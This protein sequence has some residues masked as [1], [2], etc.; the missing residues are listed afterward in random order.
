MT[1]STYSTNRR[2]VL[3]GGAGIAAA[4]IAAGTATADEHENWVEAIE[5]Y[6]EDVE[7]FD[8]TIDDRR[9]DDEVEITV[10]AGEAGLLFDPAAVQVSPGT[11]VRWTWSGEGGEHNVFHDEDL[12]DVD[13]A[14]FESEWTDD[15]DF[16]YEY[17]F[18]DSGEYRYVCEP[19]RGQ[20]MKG[21]ILVSDEDVEAGSEIDLGIGPVG[22]SFIGLLLAIPL[23]YAVFLLVSE[24]TASD[25]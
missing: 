12:D 20:E 14:A 23:F 11:T 5:E 21:A 24:M 8:G 4:S 13:E 15:P 7:N 25:E 22:S 10:G 17:T 1:E 16:D 18:E 19:H 6:L 3:R 9:N 2:T